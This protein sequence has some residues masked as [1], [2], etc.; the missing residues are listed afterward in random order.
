MKKYFI[1]L[2]SLLCSLLLSS[3]VFATSDTVY[4]T[5]YKQVAVSH[6]EN[7]K[8]VEEDN[9]QEVQLFSTKT[10]SGKYGNQLSGNAKKIYK[11]LVKYFYTN[12][13]TGTLTL[14]TKISVTFEAKLTGSGK[15]KQI[16]VS[17]KAFKKADDKIWLA[18]YYASEAFAED[19]PEVF[20]LNY[21]D[22]DYEVEVQRN[23]SYSTGYKG[24]MIITSLYPSK[25][26]KYPGEFFK[27]ASKR[28]DE[29]NK[30][31]QKAV[32]KIKKNIN[33]SNSRLAIYLGIHDYICNRISYNWS[34]TKN[35]K[36]T[37][38]N[39]SANVFLDKPYKNRQLLCDGYAEG[40]KVLCDAF[41]LNDSCATIVGETNEGAHEWNY[42]KINKKWYLIDVTWDDQEKI[43]IQYDYFL[44]GKNSQGFDDLIKNERVSFPY[45]SYSVCNFTLP[46][47]A[48][49]GY[50]DTKNPEA[51][52]P[53]LKIEKT[54]IA[55]KYSKKLTITNALELAETDGTITYTSDNKKV[56]TVNAK[57]GKVTVVGKGKC[58]ITAKTKKENYYKTGSAKYTLTVK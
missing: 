11:E 33:N 38:V 10:Y 36:V 53:V 4:T 20:W 17:T 14:K 42:V 1:V 35:D 12:Q 44:A 23:S 50:L 49:T 41:G 16:D 54:K 2:F 52:T 34:A 45:F 51:I 15:N 46:I 37:Y 29:Y 43:G 8:Q 3:T 7:L 28:I 18:F 27:G 40:F 24:I 26:T 56:A 6:R 55:K 32:K 21:L 19:Y 25:D 48:S 30:G 57:T 5:E 22:L 47:L 58:T 31:V 39:T 9:Q 13:K